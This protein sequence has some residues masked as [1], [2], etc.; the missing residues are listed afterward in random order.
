MTKLSNRLDALER[1]RIEGSKRWHQIIWHE[2]QSFDEMIAANNAEAIP[3]EDNVTIIMIVPV[4]GDPIRDRDMPL[5][6][7]W[8]E[9]RDLAVTLHK[10]SGSVSV[11]IVE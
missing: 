2:G 5:Y 3:L 10:P 4:G 11:E 7:A 8:C 1:R 9:Q 6:E